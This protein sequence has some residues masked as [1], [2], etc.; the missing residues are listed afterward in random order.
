MIDVQAPKVG[1]L[2]PP[3]RARGQHWRSLVSHQRMSRGLCG[4]C[5]RV[6]SYACPRMQIIWSN[7]MTPLFNVKRFATVALSSLVWTSVAPS[8]RAEIN[9][10]EFQL[11]RPEL[12]MG[13]AVEVAVRLVDK[14]LGKSVPD[15]VIFAQRL[16]MAPDG[17]ET[18]TAPIVLLPPTEP[19][20]YR[21]KIRLA[22]P[23]GWRL[24]LAA[25]VQ[26]EIGTLE[27]KLAFKAVP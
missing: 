19:G 1:P 3:S 25:K 15:A 5:R 8:A 7:R 17:M 14:R 26:G 12:R 18:M 2:T 23:G 10:Y 13:E 6:S 9:D 16:D 21:F 27:N 24:S 11:L 22:M 4:K 20:L